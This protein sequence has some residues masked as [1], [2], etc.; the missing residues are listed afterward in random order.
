MEITGRSR[1]TQF[2]RRL[3]CWVGLS[4]FLFTALFTAQAVDEGTR[5]KAESAKLYAEGLELSKD[6]NNE[7]ALK[8]G[9]ALFQQASTNNCPDALS[10]VAMAQIFG[11]GTMQDSSLGFTTLKLAALQGSNKANYNLSTLAF[12]GNFAPKDS[13]EGIRLLEVAAKN[14]DVVSQYNL[15]RRYMS[16]EFWDPN[17]AL[18]WFEAAA[19]QGDLEAKA[20]VGYLHLTEKV[21]ASDPVRGLKILEEVA[22]KKVWRAEWL[23]GNYYANSS[24]AHPDGLK[25]FDHLTRSYELEQRDY[26]NETLTVFTPFIQITAMGDDKQLADH[27]L[28]RLQKQTNSCLANYLLGEMYSFKDSRYYDIAKAK[29]VYFQGEKLGCPLASLKLG[30]LYANKGETDKEGM[31]M[32]AI[33]LLKIGEHSAEASARLTVIM[34]L[35]AKTSAD[36]EN[37]YGL[38]RRSIKLGHEKVGRTISALLSTEKITIPN[39][40]AWK[41]AYAL[42]ATDDDAGKSAQVLA[43]GKEL[44]TAEQL[45]DGLAFWQL[46][47]LEVLKADLRNGRKPFRF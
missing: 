31:A 7:E 30:E 4:L 1:G 10:A 36:Y 11:F 20:F 22:G 3:S 2:I 37:A 24:V 33:H 17:Q 47:K 23:L 21:T 6:L 18:H 12:L 25:A 28:Q 43:G 35:L 44:L 42:L 13:K 27:I 46:L 38:G 29:E 5:L 40:E 16:P 14:G 45:K 9:F 32:A 8:R 41:Y 15:A 19:K 34:A 39:Q 26:K